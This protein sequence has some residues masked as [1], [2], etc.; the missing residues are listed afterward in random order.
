MLIPLTYTRVI[1]GNFKVNSTP[2][3][4]IDTYKSL[5]TV[6]HEDLSEGNLTSEYSGEN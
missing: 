4:S 2:T 3:Q 6:H 1:V 5:T